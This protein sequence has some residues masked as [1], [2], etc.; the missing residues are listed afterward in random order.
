MDS[1]EPVMSGRR[2]RCPGGSAEAGVVQRSS[3]TLFQLSERTDQEVSGVGP[4]AF[5]ERRDPFPTAGD[6]SLLWAFGVEQQRR[7]VSVRGE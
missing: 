2:V 4:A 6:Q 7:Q 1:E 5:R 3:T